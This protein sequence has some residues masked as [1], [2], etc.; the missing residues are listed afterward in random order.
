MVCVQTRGVTTQG[1][2]C[3]HATDRL[4]SVCITRRASTCS[5]SRRGGI[6]ALES[7]VASLEG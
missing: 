2:S 6:V 4:K 1:C 3:N 7:N 5:S